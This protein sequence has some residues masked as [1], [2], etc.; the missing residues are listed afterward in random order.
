MSLRQLAESHVDLLAMNTDHFAEPVKQTRGTWKRPVNHAAALVTWLQPSWDTTAG[1]ISRQQAE[2]H[3]PS[4]SDVAPGD[5]FIIGEHTAVVTAIGEES[6][7]LKRFT[8]EVR[9]AVVSQSASRGV[10]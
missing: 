9:T 4:A 8:V 1:Q 10:R 3:L 2:V 7:G 5:V 6:F